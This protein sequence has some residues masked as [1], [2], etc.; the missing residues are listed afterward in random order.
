MVCVG[1]GAGLA[2]QIKGRFDRAE[3]IDDPRLR[4]LGYEAAL[5]Y[6]YRGRKD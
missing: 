2:G 5:G 1:H 6:G 3:I 4:S